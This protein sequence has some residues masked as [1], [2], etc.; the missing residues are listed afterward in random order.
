MRTFRLSLLCLFFCVT[1]VAQE[2]SEFKT[3]PTKFRPDPLW[4][5]NNTDITKEGID[6]QMPGFLEKCGYG[7]LAILPF[8]PNLTPKYLTE[9][10]FERYKYAVEKAAELGLTLSLYDEY[11]FPSGSGGAINADGVPRFRNRFPN[12]TMKRLDKIEEETRGGAT[13]VSPVSKTGQLMAAVAMNADTKER[14]DLSGNITEE[15]IVWKVPEGNWKIM[16]F[17]CVADDDPNMDY[18]SEEAAKAYISMTHE[19][20]YKRM[21]EYFGKTITSTFFDEPTLYRAQ[22]RC[23]TPTFNETYIKKYGSS[24]ALY[25]PAL[26]YDIG[27]ETQ[28]ARNALF[29]LR[30]ELY[31][32]AYPKAVSEWSKAHGIVATGHQDNEEIENPVG[33]SAD[34]MK[35]FKYQDVPGIDKIGGDRP[36]EKFYKIVSSAAYNW[37]HSLVMSETYGAMGNIPWDTLYN[38]AMDQYSKGINMLI[39]HAVWF[40]DRDVT[41]EPELSHR[42][43]LYNQGLYEFN[44][45]LARLNMLLRNDDRFVTDVAM[46]YPIETMQGEHYFDGPLGA[47]AGGVK[48]PDMDYV[49]ISQRLTNELGRDFQFLHPEVLQDACRVDKN[50]LT[51]ANTKQYNTFRTLIVPSS[52]TI[53]VA[54]LAKILTFFEAGGQ[55]IF[56]TQLPVKST[57]PNADAQVVAL[58]DKL[59]PEKLRSSGEPH[60]NPAGGRVVFLAKPGADALRNALARPSETFDVEFPEGIVPMRYI[61]K[62]RAG[63]DIYYF[64]NLNGKAFDSAVAL[65]GKKRYELWNPHTG[66]VT[67]LQPEYAKKGKD[68]VSLVRLRVEPS[69]SVFLVETK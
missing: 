29:G 33:T 7:G 50:G 5:W 60:T 69:Q 43:R 18:L 14:I 51:L 12:L 48:I 21:P 4:F 54:N 1:A 16:Q 11:G 2:P 67:A 37:D 8:G 6:A 20:Y 39:P 62:E 38:V 17:V 24:P 42:N 26:W 10:Y 41:F 47:Y 13:Y 64:A 28:A 31:A 44:T 45:F 52:K 58:M 15:T 9:E 34:L 40:N 25:Y 49:Q 35:C 63:K 22:A 56:T 53:S 59:L 36:A 66:E 30:A 57:E 27:P 19:A 68:R 23:W 46:L 61:H 32:A 65:R 3:P 55:V